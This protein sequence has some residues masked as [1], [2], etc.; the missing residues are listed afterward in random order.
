[1]M[2]LTLL[3][4]MKPAEH[5]Y[6]VMGL[7]AYSKEQYILGPLEV[8]RDTYKVEGLEFKIDRPIK[9]HYQYFKKRLEGF[10][11]DAI[12]GALQAWTEEL[13]CQ[14][15]SNWIE[16]TGLNNVVF[17]GGV[18][19]NIKAGKKI[20]ELDCVQDIFIPVAG[21]DESTS[22]G[23]AQYVFCQLDQPENLKEVTTPYISASF[24]E[25]DVEKAL[26]HSFLQNKFLVERNVSDQKVAKLLSNGHVVGRM[27]GSMEF[28]PRALGHRSLL[29]DPRSTSV[30]A[31]LNETIKNRDFWM[32]FTPSILDE[33]ADKYLVN[34]KGLSSP[35]MTMAF[36]STAQAK[37]DLP[38]AMHAYDGSIRPQI[39]TEEFNA[40]Y[41][42]LLKAFERETGIGGLLNTSFNI[43]GK[44]IVH[45]PID[46]IEEVL[47]HELVDLKFV[48]INDILVSRIN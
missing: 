48:M 20:S 19:L 29:A 3:L 33:Y 1:M 40:D 24:S 38:A 44:P 9:N 23:A 26:D 45:R 39:V 18:A 41:Y 36:E 42:F 27:H 6:K 10:R 2:G 15:V 22:L 31:K 43:H 13:L 35:Y 12:A 28:G 16:E 34:P 47:M 5:E 30:V 32:P 46:V 11:F 7:A 4:G 25:V 21:G 14:F 37:I 17:S 8:F